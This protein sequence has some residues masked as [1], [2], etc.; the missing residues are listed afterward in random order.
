MSAQAAEAAPPRTGLVKVN[1]VAF[2]PRNVRHSLGDL[3]SLTASIKRVGLLE[4]IVVEV[5]GSGLRLRAGARRLAACQILGLARVPAV[6]HQTALSETEW[7]LQALHENGEREPLTPA[8]RADAIKR[9]K[10][11]GMTA[12]QIADAM[13]VSVGTIRNWAAGVEA[14][15]AHPEPEPGSAPADGDAPDRNAA[16]RREPGGRNEK[17]RK[18]VGASAL[19]RFAGA[20][21]QHP[22]ATVDDVLAALDLLAETG[23]VTE[24]L[25]DH[26]A[27]E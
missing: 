12:V 22:G 6:I 17:T 14:V 11:G 16:R 10:Q 13:H 19:R 5:Y 3:R 25:P 20:W 26:S 2:H 23:R 4:P 27:E 15:T 8:E 21:R 7:V 9:L 24:A 18:T 1:D